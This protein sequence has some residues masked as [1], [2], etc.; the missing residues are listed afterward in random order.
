VGDVLA[1][2]HSVLQWHQHYIVQ[3]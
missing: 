1:Q 3:S 2:G